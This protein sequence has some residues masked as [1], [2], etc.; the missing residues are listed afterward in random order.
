MKAEIYVWSYCPHCRA[1]LALLEERGIPTTKHVMDTKDA[2]LS[3][4]KKRYGHSTVPIVLLD[5]TFIGGN[6]ALKELD[7]AGGLKTN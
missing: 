1:A 5:G 3:E 2:E 4:V 7:A 6:D